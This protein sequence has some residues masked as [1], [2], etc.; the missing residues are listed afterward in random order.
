V[1]TSVG[2]YYLNSIKKSGALVFDPSLPHTKSSY[3]LSSAKHPEIIAEF[4][5]FLKNRELMKKIKS[6]Y[7]LE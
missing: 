6:K 4:N 2:K 3:K 7:D 1:Q 5:E